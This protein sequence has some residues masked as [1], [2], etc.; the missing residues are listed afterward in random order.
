MKMNRIAAAAVFMLASSSFAQT[1]TVNSGT[2]NVTVSLTPVCGV[3]TNAT[4]IDFGTYTPFTNAAVPLTRTVVFRCS[5]GITPSSIGLTSTA[6]TDVTTSTAGT[7]AQTAEGVIK[8]LR[9]TLGIPSLADALT[10]GTAGTAAAAGTGGTGGTNSSA[11][12][13][14]FLIN[15]NMPGNQAGGVGGDTS[16][17][18]R[19]DLVY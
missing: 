3:K 2:F 9:Y 4:D 1:T 16:H 8:G 18:W 6:G 5:Q 13:Y 12:E 11:K 14:S 10:A 7:G 17:T 19:L 15:A